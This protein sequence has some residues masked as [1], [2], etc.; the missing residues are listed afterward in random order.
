MGKV[1][2]DIYTSANGMFSLTVPVDLS[3]GGNGGVIDGDDNVVFTYMTDGEFSVNSFPHSRK[4]TEENKLSTTKNALKTI[5]GQN[6]PYVYEE[7]FPSIKEGTT[8]IVIE[9]PTE[10]EHS[11]N[12][13]GIGA[14][15]T[16]TRFIV[17]AARQST[18]AFFLADDKSINNQ[19]NMLK[20]LLLPV[21][22]T[23]EVDNR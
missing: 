17:V 3:S 16:K 1:E 13:L 11:P 20:D 12:I 8:F 10:N 5:T 14:F 9:L 15:W 4:I 6:R 2:N 19:I 18:S 7:Y 23:V 22:K 21:L